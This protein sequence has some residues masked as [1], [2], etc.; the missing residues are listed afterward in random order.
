MATL[1]DKYRPASWDEL[2]GQDD[3]KRRLIALEQRGLGGRAYWLSGKSG[4]GKT[5]IAR[6]IA[7]RVAGEFGTIELEAGTMTPKDVE[8]LQRKTRCRP[9]G[10]DGWCFVINE[11]HGL[12]SDTMRALLPVL[13]DVKAHVAWC[14]TTTFEGQRVLFDKDDGG[15]LA[16]RCVRINLAV[17]ESSETMLAA[18]LQNVAKLEAL[19]GKPFTHYVS[20]LRKCDGNL[21]A[22][23]MA[24]ESGECL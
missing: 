7:Q 8:D 15:P 22:A 1:A 10:A 5:S 13:E 19:D 21:R 6:L 11:A 3:A 2:Y 23:L 4:T 20:L 17:T 18:R 12:R 14:F 9:I 16:S 24:V